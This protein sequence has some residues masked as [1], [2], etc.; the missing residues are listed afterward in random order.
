M[1]SFNR[2]S[3]DPY[4]LTYETVDVTEVCNKEKAVPSEWITKNGTD[5][6]EELIAYMK[7]L[8]IGEPKVPVKD[9]L[10]VFAYRPSK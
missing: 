8:I 10:P 1:I 3:N 5:I 6:S 4:K 9:G 7:P 2:V